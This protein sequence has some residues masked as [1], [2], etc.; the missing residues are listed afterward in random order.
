MICF[1][2]LDREKYSSAEEAYEKG[3]ILLSEFD[4]GYKTLENGVEIVKRQ[5]IKCRLFFKGKDDLNK[6][7]AEHIKISVPLEYYKYKTVTIKWMNYYTCTKE[8]LGIK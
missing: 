8:E 6:F 2:L 7:L 4:R 1:G 5:R 3:L